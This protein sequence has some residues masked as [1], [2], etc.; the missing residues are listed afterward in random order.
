MD[1]SSGLVAGLTWPE[2]RG[3]HCVNP[4]PVCVPDSFGPPHRRNI[5]HPLPPHDASRER[6]DEEQEL[7]RYS[8]NIVL[9]EALV[10]SALLAQPDADRA[11]LRDKIL[12]ML[13]G[14]AIGDAMGAPT[15][16]WTRAQIEAEYG[17]VRDLH[18][19]MT[20]PSPEGTWELNVR[21]GTTTDDTR[22]KALAIDYLSET[23]GSELRAKDLAAH[24]SRRFAS[25]IDEL[26]QLTM[27]DPAPALIAGVMRLL[28]ETSGSE[29]RAKD[30]AAHLSR[31]FASEID[32]LRQLTMDDP[33]PALIAG[34]MRLQ[35]LEE[36]ERVARA[37]LGGDLDE[38]SNALNRFYGGEMVCAGLLFAP[39]LGAYYPGEP[40]AAY[41]NTFA[42]D[43]YDLGY[44][45]DVSAITAAM[46][47]AAIPEGATP[48]S[49][50]A[51]LTDVDPQGF[52]ESRLIGRQAFNMLRDAR[53]IVHEARQVE[54]T[55]EGL[56]A[57][58]GATHDPWLDS[59]LEPL[60]RAR[61]RDAYRQLDELRQRMPFHAGE[62]HLVNL[63]ALIYSEFDFRRSLEFVVN[64]GR[65]NDTTAAV[66]GAVV[67]AYVGREALP[68]S[69]V[70]TT[71]E[72]NR[73]LG[74]DLEALTDRLVTA[75]ERR[76]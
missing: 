23:S 11:F 73:A 35:W 20:P 29:L 40:E 63:T 15:E 9:V 27:D 46:V 65:D 36:W 38:Y 25:E 52:F 5:E 34:V 41:R 26:R 76:R 75:I 53:A 2:S 18:P 4:V 45:K 57:A 51:V 67:G 68:E 7:I 31:R 72:G 43:V 17:F 3:W 66:T 32:E 44:A 12:G 19:R 70:Q 13:V 8:P 48:E 61:L 30:L 10:V 49:I 21:A 16:M 56:A 71:L 1:R 62:I 69:W 74:L 33:A 55:G 50:L 14:S 64:Y 6:G 47:A 42:V 59:G 22:W 24:L 39:T 60:E 37:Y 28:S 58:K 54:L